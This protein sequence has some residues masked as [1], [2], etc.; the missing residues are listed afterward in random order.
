[1]LSLQLHQ[2]ES[3]ND[4][5]K[6]NWNFVAQDN[7][8]I[9]YNYLKAIE[10]SQVN[11]LK[12]YYI[13]TSQNNQPIGIVYF[14][15]L[16]FDLT[17]I[18]T[19]YSNHSIKTVREWYPDFMNSRLLECGHISGIGETIISRNGNFS[20]VLETSIEKIENIAN[21]NNVDIIVIRDIPHEKFDLYNKILS[22]AT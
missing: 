5:Q 6:E 22:I 10:K 4:F 16:D 12:P 17:G 18:I 19:D 8:C 20:N 13:I 14:G 21:K 15:I 1:M 9:Q 7:T 3:I 2:Y 11:N